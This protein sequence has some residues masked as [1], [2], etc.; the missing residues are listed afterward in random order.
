MSVIKRAA[1]E[2]RAFMAAQHISERVLANLTRLSYATPHIFVVS[3]SSSP[4][5]HISIA[6]RRQLLREISWGLGAKAGI[7]RVEHSPL[8]EL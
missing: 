8:K 2:M 4:T 3:L 7:G 5:H 1:I 6:E